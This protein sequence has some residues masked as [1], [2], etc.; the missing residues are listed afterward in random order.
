MSVVAYTIVIIQVVIIAGAAWYWLSQLIGGRVNL[1]R[2][3]CNSPVV[4]CNEL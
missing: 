2:I 4:R 1:F 3:I